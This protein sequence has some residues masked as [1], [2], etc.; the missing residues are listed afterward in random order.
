MR[1]VISEGIIGDLEG[2]CWLDLWLTRDE[3]EK[4]IEQLS[5]GLRIRP[6]GLALDEVATSVQGITVQMNG[7]PVHELVRTMHRV[8]LYPERIPNDAE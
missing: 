2:L 5:L 1:I 6:R 7:G 8:P 3:A 4:A